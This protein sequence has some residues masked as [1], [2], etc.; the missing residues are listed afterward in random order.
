MPREIWHRC[1]FCARRIRLNYKDRALEHETPVCQKYETS[2]ADE[3]VAAV[4][5]GEHYN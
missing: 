3:Y 2:T 5:R 4:I 1:F